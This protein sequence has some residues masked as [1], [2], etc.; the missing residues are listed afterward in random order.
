MPSFTLKKKRVY[1]IAWSLVGTFK[2]RPKT[3]LRL[4]WIP[5]KQYVCMY[6]CMYKT[7]PKCTLHIAE[8][9]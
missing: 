7:Q 5:H 4:P 8:V 6:V 9:G 2:V 3:V 1:L